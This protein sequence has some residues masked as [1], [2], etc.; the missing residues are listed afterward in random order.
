M[1]SLETSYE[2]ED[3]MNL[4]DFQILYSGGNRSEVILL[5]PLLLSLL[6]LSYLAEISKNF[7][8]LNDIVK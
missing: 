8:I 3:F 4:S 1:V 5:Y 6:S 2:S 7:K